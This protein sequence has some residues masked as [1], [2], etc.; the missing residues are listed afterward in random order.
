MKKKSF[1]AE[2]QSGHKEAAVEVPFDP[3]QVGAGTEAALARTTGSRSDWKL[4]WVP[5]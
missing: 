2:V 4:E 1:R 5:L 3:A